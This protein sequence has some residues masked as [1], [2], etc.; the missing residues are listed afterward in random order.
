MRV[1]SADPGFDRLG[2]A[3]IDGPRGSEAF[4]FS[5]CLSSDKTAEFSERLRDLGEQF[6]SLI[7]LYKPDTFAIEK[8]AFNSNQKT[9]MGVAAVRG[10][11]LYEAQKHGLS[12]FEYTPQAIKTATTGYGKSDKKQ[13][14]EMVERLIALPTKKRLD[15]EYDAI[16]VA[17]TCIASEIA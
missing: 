13:V 3:V 8:L 14:A 1:L 7:A 4:V 12:I 9:A 15:D 11:L 2:I 16:A 5:D 6:V 17:L 10:V